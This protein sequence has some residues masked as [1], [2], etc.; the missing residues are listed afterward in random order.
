MIT[1]W[2]IHFIFQVTSGISVLK[3]YSSYYSLTSLD[4]ISKFK[5][6][7]PLSLQQQLSSLFLDP[8]SQSWSLSTTLTCC[9]WEW[10][11]SPGP[12]QWRD[13]PW[14]TATHTCPGTWCQECGRSHHISQTGSSSPA[15]W[16]CWGW[17]GCEMS[18]PRWWALP[19]A[20]TAAC[21]TLQQGGRGWGRVILC[22]CCLPSGRNHS[23]NSWGS[24]Q[25]GL[26][27]Q[28]AACSSCSKIMGLH[29]RDTDGAQTRGQPMLLLAA[30]WEYSHYNTTFR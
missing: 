11:P 26:Y 29:L 9:S 28:S 12:C 3:F 2:G 18:P 20:P 6:W 16:R 27:F 21:S 30:L 8:C 24:S 23:T 7:T 1:F 19:P 5:T 25:R 17:G 14:H 4:L 10:S 15:G 22:C 13:P